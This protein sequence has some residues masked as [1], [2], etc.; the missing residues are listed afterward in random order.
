MVG[1]KCKNN[2]SGS[3]IRKFGVQWVRVQDKLSPIKPIKMTEKCLFLP[4]INTAMIPNAHRMAIFTLATVNITNKK[5][6]IVFGLID[7]VK[8]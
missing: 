1:Q 4:I 8:S 5:H 2:I 7:D 3:N 6:V